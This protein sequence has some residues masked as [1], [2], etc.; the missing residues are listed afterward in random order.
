MP[1]LQLD[2]P[3]H[4]PTEVK[5]A[6]AKRLGGL[7]ADIMQTS[8]GNVTVAFR[9][10]GEGGLWRCGGNEPVPAVAITCDIRRGRPAEQRARLAE[11]LVA[12][13]VDALE[14]HDAQ[15]SVGFTQHTGDEVFRPGQGLYKDWT[16][17][18][19]DECA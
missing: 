5:R 4:Y 7:F 3:G 6:L 14:L 18:E 10:L 16:P 11:V 15:L 13:C 2:I 9:E 8:H 19:A 17:A 12:A 1:Y